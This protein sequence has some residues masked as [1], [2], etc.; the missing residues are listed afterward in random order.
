MK[1]AVLTFLWM[2]GWISAILLFS[3]C[4]VEEVTVTESA[5]GATVTTT[6]KSREVDPH[7]W[8]IAEIGAGYITRQEIENRWKP[9]D[10]K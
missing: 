4:A 6:R 2:L 3:G 8:R 9:F 1:A 5:K 7:A 10:E